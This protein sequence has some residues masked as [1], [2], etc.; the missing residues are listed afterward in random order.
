[1]PGRGRTTPRHTVYIFSLLFLSYRV[2]TGL[3]PTR[4]HY[5]VRL[6]G[7]ATVVS[8][9][10]VLPSAVPSVRTACDAM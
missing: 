9:R 5:S 4:W 1:M 2:H 10:L 6:Y 7:T 3:A 8:S